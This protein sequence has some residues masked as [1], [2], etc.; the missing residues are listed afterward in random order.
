MPGGPE[1]HAKPAAEKK[2][3]AHEK[4]EANE[5]GGKE[6][7][8]E[9]RPLSRFEKITG[10]IKEFW[11]TQFKGEVREKTEEEEFKEALEPTPVKVA[12]ATVPAVAGAVA[13]L[14][15]VKAL[16]DLP[17]YL[18]QKYFTE[19]EKSGL[20]EAFERTKDLPQEQA[21]QQEQAVAH[22]VGKDARERIGS[23]TAELR[24]KIEGSK[25]MT[26]AKK[27]ELMEK[28]AAIEAK[29]GGVLEGAA[30][31]RDKE[32]GAAID[33]AIET[34]IK[35]TAALKETL[36]TMF[37]ASGLSAAR[38]LVFGGVSL[39]E[40]YRKVSKEI[41]SG[42]REGSVFNEMV[43]KG[44]K[45]TFHELTFQEGKTTGE[46]VKN[47]AEALASVLRFGGMAAVG[48]NELNQEGISG[49]I[50]KAIEGL[51]AQ[52][53]TEFAG[54]NFGEN[55]HHLMA[56][57]HLA[58]HGDPAG[59]AAEAAAGH[60]TSEVAKHAS[61]AVA[62]GLMSQEAVSAIQEGLHIG[63]T[64]L[65]VGTKIHEDVEG[66]HGGGHGGGHEGGHGE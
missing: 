29:H 58:E 37:V 49:A 59:H 45:E 56:F 31:E 28:V 19:R 13:S 16:A 27:A 48:L 5:A 6:A 39:F 35:G 2:D 1:E 20:R 55:A 40:R 22:D 23:R 51:Q 15:G 52:S 11:A 53:V 32:F 14:F 34:K 33:E 18:T 41:E 25:Y 17:R 57:M 21:E 36:N 54:K 26:A 38:A 64:K 24:A 50:S 7:A 46:K 4:G 43:V 10:K 66:G 44:L 30:D 63:E 3:A 12:K 62:G 61:G 8:S 60:G 9:D 47:A 65:E 42:K